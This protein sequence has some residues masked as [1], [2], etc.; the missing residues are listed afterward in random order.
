M[1]FKI[2][3]TLLMVGLFYSCSKDG[4]TDPSAHNF[5]PNATKDDGSCFY[6]LDESSASFTFQASP[7]NDN[8]IIF[9]AD[10]TL[11]ECVWDFGNGLNGYGTTDTAIY[12]FADTYNVTLSVFNS[13]GNA[14]SSQTVVIDSNDI[15]LFDNPLQ[16]LLSGGINGPGYRTWHIDS[17]CSMHF[18]VGPPDGFSPDWWSAGAGD[19]PGVGLYD[20]RYTFH[21]MGFQYDMVTNGDIYIH[22]TLAA[23]FPGSYENLYDYTAPFDDMLNENWN[24]TTDSILTLSNNSLI[25]FYSGVNEYKV[26]LLNDTA[27]WLQYEHHDGTLRWFARFVPEGFVTTCP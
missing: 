20:D 21:L 23:S 4:C 6:G 10:D 17:A 26:T 1:K 22:N 13:Q 12:P 16:L 11:V 8:I 5:D 18:G 25:G 2:V 27:L 15:S 24:L 14:Q 19:K 3:Y 7:N 9:T